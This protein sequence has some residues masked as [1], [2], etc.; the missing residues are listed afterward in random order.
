MNAPQREMLKQT[1]RSF[2]LT[3]RVLPGSVRPQ[4][5]LAYLLARTTDTIADTEIVPPEQR[6]R[7]L[8]DLRARI[9]GRRTELLNFTELARQQGSP[10]ERTLL[11]QCETSLAWLRD[12]SR[13]DTERIRRVLD[14]IIGGQELDLRRF[15]GASAQNIVALPTAE[16]LDDYTYRVAGCV[17]EFWTKLCRAH[18]FPCAALDDARLLANGVRFGK[19]LQLVNI[20]RDLPGDLRKGRCYLPEKSLT[21]AGLRPQDLLD[22]ANETKM[23]ALYNR[24][25][26]QAEAHLAA[27]W[28]YT[29]SLPWRCA[30]VRLACAWPVLIGVQTLARLRVANPLDGAK[31]VKITRAL[32]RGIL[33]RSMVLYP[34]P[35]LW[36]SLVSRPRELTGNAVASED[37][38]T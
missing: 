28:E 6:L 12:C 35:G 8:A 24:L 31:P 33:W 3:L 15:A 18:V 34:F 27:G 9:L 5:G 17:G 25:L 38:F 30:R 37:D 11:E 26:A 1:S 36:R 10:A 13:A 14:I 20:L 2:Y 7:A 23:R 21:E 19:G 32:V 4:I 29:N 22:A 16:E